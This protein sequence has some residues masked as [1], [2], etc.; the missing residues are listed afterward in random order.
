MLLKQRTHAHQPCSHE[1]RASVLQ[2]FLPVAE[3]FISTFNWHLSIIPIKVTSQP[4]LFS[5]E[6]CW[7]FLKACI[8]SFYIEQELWVKMLHAMLGS[9]LEIR[10][11]FKDNKERSIEV[12]V[13]RQQPVYKWLSFKMQKESI[14][15]HNYSDFFSLLSNRDLFTRGITI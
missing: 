14:L 13:E 9:N 7:I 12:G 6:H 10:H 4:S 2:S 1:L 5:V 3:G 11:S 8:F 15:H